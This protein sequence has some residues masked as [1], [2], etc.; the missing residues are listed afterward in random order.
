MRAH[1]RRLA[2]LAG[3]QLTLCLALLMMTCRGRRPRR[4]RT[5]LDR[6]LF[7]SVEGVMEKHPSWGEARTSFATTLAAVLARDTAFPN[8]G[9]G[10]YSSSLH[11]AYHDDLPLRRCVARR[12]AGL[13]SRTVARQHFHSPLTRRAFNMVRKGKVD[14]PK[15]SHHQMI[16]IFKMLPQRSSTR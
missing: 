12:S 16:H 7:D 10:Y 9:E 13:A 11:R 8:D 2:V 14:I 15:L 6:L 4:K 5:D 3:I 1:L